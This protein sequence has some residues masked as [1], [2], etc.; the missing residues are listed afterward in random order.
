MTPSPSLAARLWLWGPVGAQMAVIFAAS[1]VT[2]PGPLTGGAPD[3]AGHGAGYGVLAAL[4]LRALAGGRLAR[5]T[6]AA[7]LWAVAGAAIYGVTDEWHQA[8]V[9][10]RSPSLADLA[11]DTAG[12]VLAAALGWAWARTRVR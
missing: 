2:D 4:L 1:S 8:F 9:P 10:G 11:A 3:W 6:S 5:V 12:A 7:A